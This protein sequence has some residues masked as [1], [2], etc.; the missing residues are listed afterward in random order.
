MMGN[1]DRLWQTLAGDIHN[2][3]GALAGYQL[4][5]PMQLSEAELETVYGFMTAS[6]FMSAWFDLQRDKTRRDDVFNTT[7]ILLGQLGVPL[8]AVGEVALGCEALCRQLLRESRK[9]RT[10]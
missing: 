1:Y 2:N 3:R 5:E 6:M 7:C 4:F 8:N 9:A 10:A